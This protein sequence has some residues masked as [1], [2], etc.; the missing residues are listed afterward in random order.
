MDLEE[1]WAQYETIKTFQRLLISWYRKNGRDYPWR[2]TRDPYAILVSEMMLQQTRIAVVLNRG[3]YA[4]WMNAFPTWTELAGASEEEVLTVWQGLGY[5]NRARYLWRTAQIITHDYGGK[6]PQNLN[7]VLALPGIGRYSAGA[8][9]SFAFDQSVPILDGNIKRI[10][11]RIFV[12]EER[13]DD[14]IGE[15]KLWALAKT[16]LPALD[17]RSFNSAL[18]E[19]GQTICLPGPPLCAS[20]PVSSLCTASTRGVSNSYPKKREKIHPTLCEEA[21]AIFEN[22]GHIFLIQEGGSRRRG[23]WRLPSISDL[24][25]SKSR[26]LIE[27]SY[28]ITRYRVRLRVFLADL[29]HLKEQNG[30]WI[31]LNSRDQW[32][33]LGAPYRKAI[34]RYCQQRD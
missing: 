25:A 34:E 32:P 14:Y 1:T 4:R 21:V 33:P 27:F 7:E 8:V 26:E 10:F 9:L 12:I 15:K 30:I 2:K 23:L 18:M 31:P 6:F 22:D 3:F 20:C 16:L 5:Y 13:I 19:L 28:S 17:A 24:D 11:S 29:Q